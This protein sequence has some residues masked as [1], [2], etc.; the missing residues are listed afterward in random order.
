MEN[1]IIPTEKTQN[2][3][4]NNAIDVVPKPE[5]VNSSLR[6]AKQKKGKKEYTCIKGKG[7][8]CNDKLISESCIKVESLTRTLE[9]TEWSKRIKFENMDGK[10]RTIDIPCRTIVE[11]K[12]TLRILADAGFSMSCDRR[13]L[14]EYL[15]SA[16]PSERIIL[17]KKIGWINN[18]T[19]ETKEYICPSFTVASSCSGYSLASGINDYGFAKKGTLEEWQANICKHCEGNSILT[20]ALCVGLS[21][22]LLKFFPTIGTTIINLVGRS[23]I[24]KTSVLSAVASLWGSRK[25]L[26]QWRTT[27]NAL[28]SVAESHNDCLLI[29]DELSQAP[30]KDIGNIVY[31][32]G[33]EKGK[34]RL[35]VDAGIRKSKEWRLSILSSGEVGISDK[36]NE[37]GERTKAGQLMRCIDID[38]QVSDEF[39]VYDCLHNFNDGAELS[40][41]LK[42]KSVEY[43]GTAAEEFIKMLVQENDLQTTLSDLY[44]QTKRGIMEKF[45]LAEADGQVIRAVETFALILTTGILASSDYYG[46][47]TH[48]ISGI[49]MSVYAVFVRWLSDRGGKKSMEEQETV[50]FVRDFL[51]QNEDRLQPIGESG[52]SEDERLRNNRLGFIEKSESGVIYYI[53]PK[54]FKEEI[55]KG[56]NIRTVR[57]FLKKDNILQMESVEYKEGYRE[58]DKRI[59]IDGKQTMM[60]TLVVKNDLSDNNE[61]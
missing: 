14:A 35:T 34:S 39:G 11:T 31:M 29:L 22:P 61:E 21:G 6:E 57:K 1:S 59:S 3:C 4:K 46:I 49:E 12:E 19:R 60:T 17:I 43:Y 10:T 27:S 53:I 16:E 32:L 36:I 54:S 38:A 58:R 2:T 41:L 23:S 30:G 24:G 55:C 18:A 42:E 8:F 26:Q 37:G 25:F 56:R 47:L 20:F 15:V 7:L 5:G 48:N 51:L 9:S 33:N 44:K 28:E 52:K 50:N 45:R 13:G 40:N